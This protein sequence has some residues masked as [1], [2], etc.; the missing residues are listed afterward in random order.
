M[1][2]EGDTLVF[3]SA[4]EWY[5]IERSGKKPNTVR[6][7]DWDEVEAV[8]KTDIKHI[9]IEHAGTKGTCFTRDVLGLWNL[10]GVLG[11]TLFM[12]CWKP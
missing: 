7:L 12:A 3:R 10:G 4:P 9:R 8:A 1:N 11:K 2:I 5:E 6:L